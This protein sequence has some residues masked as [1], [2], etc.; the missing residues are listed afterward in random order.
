MQLAV[1]TDPS[2][3]RAAAPFPIYRKLPSSTCCWLIVVDPREDLRTGLFWRSSPALEAAIV[4]EQPELIAREALGSTARDATGL[5]GN[6]ELSQK[7]ALAPV[8][9]RKIK[10]LRHN[11]AGPLTR[12]FTALYGNARIALAPPELYFQPINHEFYHQDNQE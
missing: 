3:L 11:D 8:H 9:H 7:R 1:H 12:S 5:Q 6:R 10:S 2:A 4:Q